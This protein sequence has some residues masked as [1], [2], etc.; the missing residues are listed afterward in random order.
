M[1]HSSLWFVFPSVLLVP[2]LV[3]GWP[4]RRLA[5]LATP[6]LFRRLTFVLRFRS[7]GLLPFLL[8]R[9]PTRFDSPRLK[10]PTS[11]ASPIWPDAEHPSNPCYPLTMGLSPIAVVGPC[12]QHPRV[13]QLLR[14]SSQLQ[15]IFLA[16]DAALF[17]KGSRRW[18]GPWL[19]PLALLCL[20][21]RYINASY[22]IMLYASIMEY[23]VRWGAGWLGSVTRRIVSKP[24]P[25]S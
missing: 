1:E 11:E 15:R 16:G 18:M 3:L 10:N 6:I 8:Q 25:A 7:G 2:L 22:S 17:Q 14:M 24:V 13:W 20:V 21:V 12:W 5:G 9:R 4:R 19:W 23:T